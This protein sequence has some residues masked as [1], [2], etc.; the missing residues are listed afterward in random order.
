VIIACNSNYKVLIHTR[1]GELDQNPELRYQAV[2]TIFNLFS[3]FYLFNLNLLRY[4]VEF[5]CDAL[6]VMHVLTEMRN[7]LMITNL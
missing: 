6:F 5:F 3:N 2:I 4:K 1:G 7:V